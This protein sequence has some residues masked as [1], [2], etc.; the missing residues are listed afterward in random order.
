MEILVQLGRK[1][2]RN[3]PLLKSLSY[4]IV[5]TAGLLD[6]K[7]LSDTLFALNQLSFKVCVIKIADGT[8][9][10]F[11]LLSVCFNIHSSVPNKL[12]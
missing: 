6:L 5:K 7:Q 1:K 2:R 3:V 4:F 8:L 10:V 12:L 11:R 9:S